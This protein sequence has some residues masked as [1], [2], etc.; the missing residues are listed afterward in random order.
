MNVIIKACDFC[1][2][3]QNEVRHLIEGPKNIH[4]CDECIELCTEIIS[5]KTPKNKV[6]R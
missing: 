2:K 4:I 3:T 1:G 5:E 6:E